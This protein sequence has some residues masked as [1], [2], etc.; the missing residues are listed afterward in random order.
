MGSGVE[1]VRFKMAFVLTQVYFFPCE[2]QSRYVGYYEVMK[3][4]FNRQL[5]PPQRLK[6]KSIRIHSIAGRLSARPAELL[7]RNQLPLN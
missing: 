4:K 7:M 6:M 5:P 3:T 2:T 1:G